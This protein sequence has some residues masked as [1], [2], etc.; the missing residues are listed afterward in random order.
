MKCKYCGTILSAANTSKGRC[1]D[2]GASVPVRQKIPGLIRFFAGIF[3][4][5]GILIMLS[6]AYDGYAYKSNEE[7]YVTVDATITEIRLVVTDGVAGEDEEVDH[8]VYVDYTYEGTDYH[9]IAFDWYDVD[10]RE[11]DILP[12]TIDSRSPGEIVSNEFWLVW[13]GLAISLIGYGILRCFSK[14][15]N[16]RQ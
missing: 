16:N 5:T 10:M 14:W 15:L 12:V 3:L 11:G 7:H 1:P 6:A 2:C 4:F 13:F 8:E 9:H